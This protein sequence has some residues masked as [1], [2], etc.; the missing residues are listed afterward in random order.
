MLIEHQGHSPRV[1]PLAWV[2]PTAT[3]CG[4]VTIGAGSRILFGAVIVAESGPVDIGR[5][6]IVMENAVIRGTSR[7]PA[8]IGNHVL[9]GPHAHLSGCT[10]EDNVFIATGAAVFNGAWVST[11]AAIGIHG[12]VH[13]DA[14]LPADAFVPIGWIAVGNPVEILPPTEHEKIWTEPAMQK[15]PRM[16]FGID[17]RPAGQTIM[18]DVTTRY[19]AALGAY[20]DARVI[21]ED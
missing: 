8:R 10:I 17:R 6:T 12:V 3:I 21:Q 2:A 5:D 19:A 13:V 20:R 1:D 4:A 16:V 18:P 15:F 7:H 14:M 11:R 9:V